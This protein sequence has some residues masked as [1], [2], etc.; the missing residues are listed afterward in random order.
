M[1]LPNNFSTMRFMKLMSLTSRLS[2]VALV[3][4]S[5][6]PPAS[7]EQ[8]FAATSDPVGPNGAGGFETPVNQLVAP[9]GRL[10]CRT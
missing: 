4:A 6:L 1:D 7:A 3:L 8:G 2:I 9:E 5:C 10:N